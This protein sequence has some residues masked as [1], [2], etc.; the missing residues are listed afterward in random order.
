[1]I[2]TYRDYILSP[3]WDAKRKEKL[4]EQDRT[5]EICGKEAVTAHHLHYRTLGKERMK[6]LQALCWECHSKKHEGEER[7]QRLASTDDVTLREAKSWLRDVWEKPTACPCC[8]LKVYLTPKSF[9][10]KFCRILLQFYRKDQD[11]PGSYW[12]YHTDIE[13]PMDIRG[14]AYSFLAFWDVIEPSPTEMGFW[15]ITELGREFLL[16]RT[17]IPKYAMTFNRHRIRYQG[18]QVTI[19]ECW[20]KKFDYDLLVRGIPTE[21]R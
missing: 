14:T 5:C 12:H 10:G 19:S 9:T 8:G 21:E 1:M 3:A 15:R 11:A 7:L 17:S 18:A 13:G 4:E 20:P 16:G 6:D 2:N